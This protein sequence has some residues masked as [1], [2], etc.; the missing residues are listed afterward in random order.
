MAVPKSSQ[1]QSPDTMMARFEIL[2]SQMNRKIDEQAAQIQELKMLLEKSS[3]ARDAKD[4]TLSSPPP[5][6]Q[7]GLA[8][9]EA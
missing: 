8:I 2:A 9:G 6:C 4:R 3:D 5:N 1:S 7:H